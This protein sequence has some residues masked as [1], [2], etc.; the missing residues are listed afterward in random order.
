MIIHSITV[1]DSPLDES[2]I[3]GIFVSGTE[4]KC[5]YYALGTSNWNTRDSGNSDLIVPEWI[6]D[7]SSGTIL[8]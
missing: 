6:E 1:Y 7:G 4:T 8:E 3:E 5:Q 2:E